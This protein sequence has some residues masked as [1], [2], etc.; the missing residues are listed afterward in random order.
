[1][2][3]DALAKRHST[4]SEAIGV[5]VRMGAHR[6]VLTH[7]SQRYPTLPDLPKEVGAAVVVACDLMTL[8]LGALSWAPA[9]VPVLRCL[10]PGEGEA[11]D[12]DDDDEAEA[13]AE[14]GAG[15]GAK[16]KAGAKAGE[17]KGGQDEAPPAAAMAVAMT[18]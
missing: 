7:F 12:D 6:T 14:A 10:F 2:E 9:S 3:A 8:P 18:D 17:G 13:E 5:G 11:G 4:V 1:M 15:A 16:A